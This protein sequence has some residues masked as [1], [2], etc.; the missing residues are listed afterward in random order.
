MS[1]SV[2]LDFVAFLLLGYIEM[3]ALLFQDCRKSFPTA[4]CLGGSVEPIRRLINGRGKKLVL[5]FPIARFNFS[6]CSIC[7]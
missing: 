2:V 6:C 5:A 3:L 4:L 1:D 7:F